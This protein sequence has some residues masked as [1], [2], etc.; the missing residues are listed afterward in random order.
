ML[1]LDD[2]TGVRYSGLLLVYNFTVSI[3]LVV[4]GFRKRQENSRYCEIKTETKWQRAMT[5]N[6][7]I[8]WAV[9]LFM[10]AGCSAKG[11]LV[12]NHLNEKYL[13]AVK[14]DAAQDKKTLEFGRQCL[15]Q[16]RTVDE[17]NRCNTRVRQM[18]PQI[19]ID[20][21][22]Q[23][24]ETE[25]ARVLGIIDENLAEINCILNA[26]DIEEALDKCD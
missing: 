23:W 21:F 6:K 15:S 8:Y 16:A 13:P 3:G 18:D 14:K 5:G 12:I 4:K 9:V 2:L 7:R 25:R 20:D 22:S 24:D 17:A 1:A 11:G 10:L 19:D 26:K